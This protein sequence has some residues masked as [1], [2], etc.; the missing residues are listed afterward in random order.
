MVK[1]SAKDLGMKRVALVFVLF[2]ALSGFA[3]SQTPASDGKP[4]LLVADLMLHPYEVDKLAEEAWGGS[5]EAAPN[6]SLYYGS[7]RLDLDRSDYWTLIGA[8]NG[9][10]VAQYNA[11]VQ[12]SDSRSSNDDQKRAV[13]WLRKAAAQGVAEALLELRKPDKAE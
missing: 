11:W 1:L 4:I 8:E 9:N 13:F 6:L 3:Q 2:F 5:G 12:L 7:V 10:A